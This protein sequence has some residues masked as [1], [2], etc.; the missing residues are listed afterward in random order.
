ML[1]QAV[2][3]IDVQA[4]GQGLHLVTGEVESWVA[5]QGIASGLLTIAWAGG[6]AP[7][8]MT[9]PAELVFDGQITL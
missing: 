3:T 7:V 8:I 1:R 9:G 6:D 2:G 4:P 5:G